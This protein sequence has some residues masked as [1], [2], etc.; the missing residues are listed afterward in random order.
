MSDD[1]IRRR[2]AL[3][4]ALG[5]GAATL[6]PAWAL[7]ACGKQPLSCTDA[8]S[9][10]AADQ[11]MRSSLEYVDHSTDPKKLCSGCKLYTPGPQDQCGACSVVKGPINPAGNCKSWV[12]KDG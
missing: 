4:S 6:I 11:A 3:R 9:L 2:Q 8:T 1:K 12:A 10:A 7:T 5:F